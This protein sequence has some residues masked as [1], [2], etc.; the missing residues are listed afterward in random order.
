MKRLTG[1]QAQ[2][3]PV[4]EIVIDLPYRVR[5][6]WHITRRSFSAWDMWLMA[7]CM[8]GLCVAAPSMSADGFWC[9][10]AILGAFAFPW[11]LR[12]Y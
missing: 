10:C 4:R 1:R 9:G 11:R 7:G 6:R 3:G 2:V 12:H 8:G 5:P